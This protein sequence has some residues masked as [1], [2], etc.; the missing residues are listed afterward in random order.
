M[1]VGTLASRV[2]GFLRTAVIVAALGTGL[3]ANAYNTANTIPNQIYDL[4]L[5]GILTSVIVPLLVRAKQRD[6]AYGE[7]YEQRVFTLA[8]IG[9]GVLTVV[10]VLCAP[11]FIDVLAGSYEG[12]Q[13]KVAVLFAQFFLPQLFF[14]G[15]GAFAGAIL[16]TRGSFGAPMWAPVLNNIV[17]IAVGGAFLA[18]T[19]GRVDP[20]SITDSQ[21]MLLSVGT[22]GGI[23][24]QTVALWPSL[25]RVGFRWRPRLDFKRGEI[26]EVGRM[27]GWTLVYVIATQ[28]ALAVVTAL[29]NAAGKRAVDAGFG[30]GYGYTPYFNAYQLFQLPYAIVGVSVITALLPRMSRFA[31]EGKTA[32]VRAAFSSGLRLSSVIIMPAAALMLVLGPEITTVLF[33]HGNTSPDDALVIARVMQMFAIALVPFSIYQ[34]MLRVFYSHGDTRTPALIGL[35]VTTSNIVLAF[36]AYNVLGVKWIV[37]GIAG[38]FA[39]TNV[40]GTLTC[41]LVLRRK[42]GGIDGRRIV[43][44]HLKLLVAIWPLIGFGYAAHTVADAI[45]GGTS[46]LIPA[47]A[48]LVV[49]SVG[50]G[51][52]YVF[53]AKLMRVEEIQTTIET[54]ARR[55]PGR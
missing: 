48:T 36:S 51:L 54:F 34:L 47:L 3:L 1:A 44:G 2:T 26:G 52:L 27:A 37:V 10:A 25:R 9:L 45:A 4:L 21:L 30:E 17:V 32:D 33:A 13:R 12:D 6:R 7:Q 18:I 40:V 29:T 24:L 19:T 16:N 8:V 49:G 15:V 46:E 55:L 23:V 53:F 38:G 11:L 50:G 20:S 5:G 43:G 22:T 31:A 42:L 14:Y 35:V 41:W 39:L 28:T